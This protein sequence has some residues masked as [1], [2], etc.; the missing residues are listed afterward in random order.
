M[1]RPPATPA[2]TLLRRMAPDE[3]PYRVYE[4][5]R[6]KGKVPA[7]PGEAA[8]EPRRSGRGG[9]GA[10]RGAR[11]RRRPRCRPAVAGS[12]SS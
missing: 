5:G 9:A 12:R 1:T 6:V 4:G 3:K 7:V 2:G 11:R 8:P 10:R